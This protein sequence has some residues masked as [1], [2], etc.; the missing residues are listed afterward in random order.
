MV[1]RARAR[2]AGNAL[3]CVSGGM[4]CIWSLDV[5]PSALLSRVGAARV[6]NAYVGA[7]L[8]A[9]ACGQCGCRCV[10]DVAVLT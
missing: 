5:G 1:P 3:R 7:S 2:A 4:R 9:R 6:E 8:C 10:C